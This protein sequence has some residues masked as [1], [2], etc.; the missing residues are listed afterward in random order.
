MLGKKV[1]LEEKLLTFYGA[2]SD[3]RLQKT[4]ISPVSPSYR[5][6]RKPSKILELLRT[7]HRITTPPQKV[8]KPRLYFFFWR[9]SL[10]ILWCWMS[11]PRFHFLWPYLKP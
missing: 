1:R 8:E 10:G 9:K 6:N 11:S 2:A 3:L 5:E 4:T 7:V